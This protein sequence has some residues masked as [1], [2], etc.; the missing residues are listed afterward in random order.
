MLEN[1]MKL[2]IKNN[3]RHGLVNRVA[4]SVPDDGFK[5]FAEKDRERMK[6]LRAE[7]SRLVKVRYINYKGATEILETQYMKWDG[8]P[9]DSWRF[10]HGEE[11]EVPM[12]LVEQVNDKSKWLP[13]RSD[14]VDVNGKP[15]TK[16][17]KSQQVH[18]LI[19]TGFAA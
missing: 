18:E 11:Y 19:P 4:N 2:P 13:V 5:R 16:D 8:D 12:G 1:M 6:K 7:Q 3:M 15:T 17:G 14:V 9:I 10:I